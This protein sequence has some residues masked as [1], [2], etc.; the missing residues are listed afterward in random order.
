M[1]RTTGKDLKFEK[2]DDYRHDST[3]NAVG[4]IHKN[5]LRSLPVV[6]LKKP[7]KVASSFLNHVFVAIT[8]M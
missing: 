7:Y 6:E 8:Q 3:V 5:A 1:H 2:L 4:V